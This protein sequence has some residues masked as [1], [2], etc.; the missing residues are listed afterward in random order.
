MRQCCQPCIQDQEA[1]HHAV[2]QGLPPLRLT[3]WLMLLERSRTHRVWSLVQFIM[4]RDPA[5]NHIVL[6]ME[7]A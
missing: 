3:S 2:M 6:C 4:A 1:L 7:M 5:S